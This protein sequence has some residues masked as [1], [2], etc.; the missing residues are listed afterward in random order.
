MSRDRL[1]IFIG[2]DSSPTSLRGLADAAEMAARLDAELVG[3]FVE[4]DNL[5]RLARLPQ[6]FEIGMRSARS[7]NLDPEAIGRLFKQ[8]AERARRAVKQ[9]ADRE[10]VRSSFEV[11]RGSVI[12]Q[13]LRAL[14]GE[15]SQL[16]ESSRPRRL[17]IGEAAPSI[18][19]MQGKVCVFPAGKA[20]IVMDDTHFSAARLPIALD[21]ADESCT[22]DLMFVVVSDS[23]INARRQVAKV[24]EFLELEGR[25]AQINIL[26]SIEVEHFLALLENESCGTLIFS[27]CPK[28][29]DR[30][31]LKHLVEKIE[32]PIFLVGR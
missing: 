12:G 9:A 25:T 16:V 29:T 31:M 2:L 23:L 20:V 19:L 4:D 27:A 18:I 30:E 17:G 14:A 32:Y 7:R 22:E 24:T 11:V 10:Q 6:S 15:D 5:M 1:R 13:L 21:L 26:G 8:M 28:V 3:L